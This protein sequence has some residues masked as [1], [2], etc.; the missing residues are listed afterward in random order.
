MWVVHTWCVSLEKNQNKVKNFFLFTCVCLPFWN[1]AQEVQSVGMAKNVMLGIDLSATVQLDTI[2]HTPH[3]YAVGPVDDLQG[4]ITV[5]DGKVYTSSSANGAIT[6]IENPQVQ[7]PF[8]AYAY[9]PHWQAYTV[10]VHLNN[11]QDLEATIDS[12]GNVHGIPAGVAFP[13]RLTARWEAAT[14]H[15]IMRDQKETHHSHEAHK[16]AKV[17]F[18]RTHEQA[19]LVGFFSKNH[20]G[21]FTHKGQYIHVHYLDAARTATGHLDVIQHRGSVTVYLPRKT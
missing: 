9:V 14:F 12:L 8:L 3:C 18:D 4:E 17:L 19:D 2:V 6:T 10:D 21:I 20:E 7:S 16:K 1:I 13:F 5:F 11:L 15:I